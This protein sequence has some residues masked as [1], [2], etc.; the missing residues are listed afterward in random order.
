MPNGYGVDIVPPP[1]DVNPTNPEYR[2]GLGMVEIVGQVG[3]ELP[4]E[5]FTEGIVNF[6]GVAEFEEYAL[7]IVDGVLT[8][9]SLLDQTIDWGASEISR[10]GPFSFEL[11]LIRFFRL[12][13]KGY[14]ERQY[15]Y[16]RGEFAFLE[17]GVTK[18]QSFT[19]RMKHF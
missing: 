2:F 7:D 3:Q 12:I 6:L 13:G 11:G 18:S 19:V 10:S 1:V 4:G 5:I 14:S 9:V 17:D 15:T 16:L 8:E